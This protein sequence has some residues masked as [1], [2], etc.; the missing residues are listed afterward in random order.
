MQM[1]REILD[2]RH[3]KNTLAAIEK[4]LMA[5]D[6][7]L[8]FTGVELEWI[9]DS[10]TKVRAATSTDRVCIGSFSG[11]CAH[12]ILMR[13]PSEWVRTWLSVQDVD[14]PSAAIAF[15]SL[16]T[17]RDL[18][19]PLEIESAC[20]IERFAVLAAAAPSQKSDGAKGVKGVKR[21]ARRQRAI[22]KALTA[23]QLLIVQTFAECE[24]NYSR[25]AKRLAL[26]ASTVREQIEAA[27]KKLGQTVPTVAAKSSTKSMPVDSRGQVNVTKNR[28]KD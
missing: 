22:S 8:P 28:L 12:D 10:I 3:G 21:P 17:A 27:Y 9:L 19:L 16:M 7:K 14:L 1:M 18:P 5:A 26:S 20:K 15:T 6:S 23:K 13:A 24:S 25:T 11:A 4:H 2:A